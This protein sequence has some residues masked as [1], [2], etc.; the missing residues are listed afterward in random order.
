[1]DKIIIRIREFDRIRIKIVEFT[2]RMNT[3]KNLN[4]IFKK[5]KNYK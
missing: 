5:T 3:D 1:M 4:N 2:I